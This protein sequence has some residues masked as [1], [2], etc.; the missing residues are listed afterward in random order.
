M[1]I[2]YL[3]LAHAQP[4]MLA[5]LVARLH[6]PDTSIFVHVDAK[7][8]DF[9]PDVPGDVVFVEDRVSVNWAGFSSIRATYRLL[10]AAERSGADRFVLL[11]GADYPLV[12]QD[13]VRER[14]APDMEYIMVGHRLDPEGNG[15][16]DRR[17][18][19]FYLCD[20]RSLNPRDGLPVLRDV[21]G[22]VRRFMP[23]RR[24]DM[25]VYYGPV[26][27]TLTRDGV[28]HLM[29]VRRE[30]PEWI[31]AFKYTMAPDEMV[32]QTLLKASDRPI[33][34]DVVEGGFVP[35]PHCA[36][37]HHVNW[38]KPNPRLPRVMEMEDAEDLWASDALFARKMDLRRS[39]ELMDQID[40]RLGL[41]EA[42]PVG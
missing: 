6:G 29:K 13:A 41:R 33:A 4:E 3:I 39:A 28:A 35:P 31:E 9:R 7:T 42:V 10:E 23:R 24:F 25:Q 30:H 38:T 18:N 14:L 40:V 16:F 26:W 12:T 2:A 17:A 11:S 15:Q 21:A 27:W 20:V 32:F 34:F 22:K 19:Q 1:H 37:L 8:R 36:A 5:R